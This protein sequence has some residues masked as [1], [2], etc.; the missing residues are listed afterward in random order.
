[1]FEQLYPELIPPVLRPRQLDVVHPSVAATQQIIDT[2]HEKMQHH[3]QGVCNYASGLAQELALGQFAMIATGSG[4][5]IPEHLLGVAIKEVVAH[6]VG[7][8][9][10]LRHN[11]KASSWLSLD[12]IK[13]RRN[14]TDEPY[15]GSVMDYN[16][17]VF[18]ADDDLSKI[19]NVMTPTIGPYDEWAI[20]YGY[21]VPTGN[22]ADMLKEIAGRCTV[23]GL[24]YATDEDTLGAFSP[25]P[26]VNRFDL[27]DDPLAWSKTRV[28]LCDKLVS[29][30]TDWA[31]QKGEPRYYI[32]QAFNILWS[33]RARNFQYVTRVIG[34]QYFNRDQQGDPDARPAFQIVDGETQR[35]ALASLR[36]TL[37]ADAFFK[38][39]ADVLNMLAPQRWMD[40]SSPNSF[41]AR[42]D[43]PIHDRIL[44]LQSIAVVSLL[45]PPV[46]QRIYDA[47]LKTA[48]A[49]KFTAA[50]LLT[51]LKEQIWPQLKSATSGNYT[52]AQPMISSISR[53]LQKLYL[54]QML[55]MA[56]QT[57]GSGMSP[58][59]SGMVRFSLRELSD[60]IGTALKQAAPDGKPSRLDF[61]S[62]G[63]LTECKSNIDRVL[64]AQYVVR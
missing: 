21:K 11:F 52:D 41:S 25:D 26:A 63:H 23:A 50:E 13:R 53:N 28:D 22:E 42:V 20:E 6:E 54:N 47:E 55:Q 43:Y 18:F 48:D 46:L 64:E 37:F 45:S 44:A 36:D 9:L 39:N 57:P 58:D 27:S 60:Q 40:W 16:P 1:L 7:H 61:A 24:A 35:K 5:K 8:T 62:R 33:Q 17:L 49:K 59:L 31:A 32:T 14:E 56:Q 3:R 34:G 19:R 12:E 2:A 38:T 29:N 4:K 15:I 10:G 51:T 30:V